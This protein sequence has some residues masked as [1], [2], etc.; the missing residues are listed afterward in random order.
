MD[1]ATVKVK[2]SDCIALAQD[3]KLAQTA[4]EGVA[5]NYAIGKATKEC[6]GVTE[7]YQLKR[8]DLLHEYGSIDPETGELKTH[9]DGSLIFKN[10]MLRPEL[11]RKSQ[12]M[13][14]EEI[15][16]LIP[17]IRLSDIKTAT[18]SPDI[19]RS[20]GPFIQDE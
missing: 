13:L 9:K 8:R 11:E 6:Q 14:D 18:P 20:L 1:K 19:F 2:V 15:E 16:M 4:F 10:P 17:L 12:A 7:S 5:V 3:T